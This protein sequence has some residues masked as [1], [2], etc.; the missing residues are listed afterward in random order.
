MSHELKTP[1]S[2][3]KVLT[4]VLIFQENV[5]EEMYEEFFTDI[6]SEVDRLNNIINDLLTLVRLDQREIPMNITIINIDEMIQAI[7]R[8]LSPLAKQK[9]IELIYEGH[10]EVNA[11][12]DEV[13]LTLAISNLVENSI[14][15][16]RKREGYGLL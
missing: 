4:K 14:K 5:P 16:T 1:L 2:A 10:K 3:I 15:Y 9:G 7:L 6:N 13:K 8:R 11:E 12:I